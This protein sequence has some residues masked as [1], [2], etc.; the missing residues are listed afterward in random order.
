MGEGVGR[1]VS[2]IHDTGLFS[3]IHYY[4]SNENENRF[5]LIQQFIALFS[6]QWKLTMPACDP[7]NV[8]QL[9]SS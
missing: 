5:L 9:G 1:I 8:Q 2:T 6:S 7:M 3:S 4:D